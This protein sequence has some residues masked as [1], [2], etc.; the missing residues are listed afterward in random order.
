MYSRSV[1]CKSSTAKVPHY[2]IYRFRG[3][4]NRNGYIVCLFISDS[5]SLLSYFY[6]AKYRFSHFAKYR[7]SISQSTDF[8]FC[9]VSFRFVSFRFVPFRSISFRSI[10][11]LEPMAE[12]AHFQR[13]VR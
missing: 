1:Q 4:I 3:M 8:P 5:F 12:N 2:S 13:N 7:F 11:I 6:F 10:S 9:F